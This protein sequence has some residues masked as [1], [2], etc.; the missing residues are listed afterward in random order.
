MTASFAIGGIAGHCNQDK[1]DGATTRMPK[2]VVEKTVAWNS[3]VRATTVT[4]GDM[5]HYSGGAVIGFTATHNFLTDC[6]RKPEFDFVDYSD[7][8]GLYDQENATEETPLVVVE[9]EGANYNFPYHGKAAASGKTLSQVAQELGWSSEVWDFSGDYP[10][11]V[12]QPPL[13]VDQAGSNGQLG[14]FGENPFI[15]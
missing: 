6:V 5:S 12:G 14:D 13:V 1:G 10:V 8:F 2:N 9:V 7:L 15:Q 3:F 4:P 11:H